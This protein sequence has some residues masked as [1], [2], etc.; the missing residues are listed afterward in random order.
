MGDYEA[1]YAGRHD[2][3][4]RRVGWFADGREKLEHYGGPFHNTTEQ[5]EKDRRGR[6]ALLF[7]PFWYWGGKGLVAPPEIAELAH[8]YVGQTTSNSTPEAI[9]CLREWLSLWPVGIHGAP[10]DAATECSGRET[11]CRGRPARVVPS[12]ARRLQRSC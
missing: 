12:R 6:R 5:M 11:G 7:G 9:R 1:Q 10:R 8:Y 4:Y 2:A 3:I